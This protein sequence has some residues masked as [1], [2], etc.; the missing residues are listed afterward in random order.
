MMVSAICGLLVLASAEPVLGAADTFDGVYTGKRVLKNLLRD[1]AYAV[2][3]LMGSK[4]DDEIASS[5]ASARNSSNTAPFRSRGNHGPLRLA[6]D[7]AGV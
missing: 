5:P 7:A 6:W 1:R 4:A 3:I 2:S